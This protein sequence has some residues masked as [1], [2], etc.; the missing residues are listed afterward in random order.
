VLQDNTPCLAR[1]SCDDRWYRG[2]I[3]NKVTVSRPKNAYRVHFTDYGNVDIITRENIKLM[4]DTVDESQFPPLAS[5]FYIDGI[6]PKGPV[7]RADELYAIEKLTVY[8]E[9]TVKVLKNL[10]ERKFRIHSPAII[11][12]MQ[13]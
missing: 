11:A 10:S 9:M 7:W 13:R 6:S 4:I 12:D 1:Y 5:Q 2:R 3:M 8:K